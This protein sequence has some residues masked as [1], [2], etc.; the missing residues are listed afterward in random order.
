MGSR[1]RSPTFRMLVFCASGVLSG[2][3]AGSIWVERI[4]RIKADQPRLT[5]RAPA[6]ARPET[7]DAPSAREATPPSEPVRHPSNPGAFPPPTAVNELRMGRSWNWWTYSA[8]YYSPGPPLE[9]QG[10]DSAFAARL[11]DEAVSRRRAEISSLVMAVDEFLNCTRR[12]GPVFWDDCCFQIVTTVNGPS[13]LAVIGSDFAVPASPAASA[14]WYLRSTHPV[15]TSTASVDSLTEIL[16]TFQRDRRSALVRLFQRVEAL[17]SADAQ[18][19]DDLVAYAIID[20]RL[21]LVRRFEAPALDDVYARASAIDATYV[22]RLRH[23]LT[24]AR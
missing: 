22:D 14:R 20:R 9:Y 5:P 8:D 10:S 24:E 17:A 11:H 7:T 15:G 3:L 23:V 21:I 12:L 4:E 19:P 16:A 1:Q 18:P 13:D 6:L 2:L